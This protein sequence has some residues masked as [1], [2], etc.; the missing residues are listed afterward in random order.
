MELNG[1]GMNA[2]GMKGGEERKVSKWIHNII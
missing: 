2:R 1:R